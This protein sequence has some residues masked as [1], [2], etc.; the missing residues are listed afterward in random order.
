MGGDAQQDCGF[1]LYLAYARH[2]GRPEICQTAMKDLA[3]G[4]RGSGRK[5]MVLDQE[6]ADP[7]S[8]G[9][10]G[11]TRPKDAA[12]NDGEVEIGHRMSV[13]GAALCG[14]VRHVRA[15]A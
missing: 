13:G 10:A 3:R 9:V 14:A 7:S 8:G 2:R 1:I 15:P 4:R 12:T 6:H 5:V 11:N